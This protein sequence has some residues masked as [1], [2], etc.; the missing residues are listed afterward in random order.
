MKQA[1]SDIPKAALNLIF[2]IYCQGC[3]SQL[4]YNNKMFLCPG[5]LKGLMDTSVLSFTL[6][7]DNCY[8]DKAY[9][10]CLYEK[11]IK[12]LIHG[13]KYKKKIFLKNVLTAL[14]HSMFLRK[15]ISEHLDLIMPVPMTY[16][17]EKKRGFN[18]SY[19]LARGLSE[20]TGI[21]L[22]NALI[23]YKKTAAQAMLTRPDRLKNIKNAFSCNARHIVQGKNILLVDDVF[24]TGATINECARILKLQDADSVIA[25]TLAKGI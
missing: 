12:D 3:Q 9:H 22:E 4:D 7:E 21:Q 14:L 1:F 25:L 15:I 2:P 19:L 10:C 6:P 5:C 23:K 18:Q 13:F 16:V 20:K 11:I 8:Y 17:D 24:T